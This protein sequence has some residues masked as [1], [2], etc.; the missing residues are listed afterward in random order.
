MKSFKRNVSIIMSLILFA[1]SGNPSVYAQ[2]PM[3]QDIGQETAAACNV[4]TDAGE[5]GTI[6]P[7]FQMESG[8]SAVIKVT[9]D[10]GYVVSEFTVN[11]EKKELKGLEYTINDASGNYWISV[12]FRKKT[13]NITVSAETGGSIT[14]NRTVAYGESTTFKFTPDAGYQIDKVYLDNEPVVLNSDNTY[15]LNNVKKTHSLQAVF[16]EVE[17]SIN[18]K[19][20]ENG[21][22]IVRYEGSPIESGTVLKY[23]SIIEM[24]NIPQEHYN[25]IRYEINGEPYMGSDYRVN[26]PVD[27]TAVFSEKIYKINTRQQGS[28]TL[29][30][31]DK[32]QVEAGEKVLISAVPDTGYKVSSLIV[33][34]V[35]VT[36]LLNENFEY[37]TGDTWSGLS[38]NVIFEKLK[39]N[40][41]TECG[42]NGTITSSRTVEYG[43]DAIIS[44]IPDDAYE[45]DKVYVDGELVEVEGTDYI[46]ENV[47]SDHEVYVE[48]S[49]KYCEVEVEV[50]ENGTASPS[51]MVP[52]NDEY[53]VEI[54]PDEGYQIDVILLNGTPV[55]ASHGE[56]VIKN[57]IDDCVLQIIFEPNEIDI[58]VIT[59]VSSKGVHE[60][61]V[62]WNDVEN[63]EGYEI[64]RMSEYDYDYKLIADVPAAYFGQ[65]YLDTKRICGVEY[66][67]MVRAYKIRYNEKLYGEISEEV[68][69]MTKPGK[70]TGTSLET[71]GVK[72][73]N[74][75]WKRITSAS[76][77]EIY[78]S[79]ERDGEYTLK[80]DIKGNKTSSKIITGLSKGVRYYV[81]VRAYRIYEDEKIY[82]SF[83]SVRNAATAYLNDVTGVKAKMKG[84]E[85]SLI[86]WKKVSGAEGYD[87]FWC[88]TKNGKYEKI[89]SVKAGKSLEYKDKFYL[90]GRN[91]YKVRAYKKI[92]GKKVYG[93]LSK[94][95][96]VNAVIKQK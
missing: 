64:Y 43:K 31:D 71:T 30:T 21:T 87:I 12:K 76:G 92:N 52:Y 9:P 85:Y 13:F 41:T 38:I 22:F 42:E 15:T 33:N 44:F 84:F 45:V 5:G 39:Y 69:G 82:G 90:T 23:G 40:I 19:L 61:M 16:K 34:D 57:I 49:D 7:S 78:I 56:Y 73:L 37:E 59:K 81:K 25:F 53:V 75:K 51:T 60:L 27:I 11:D 8:G 3:N 55:F 66:Y 83:S 10:E 67:Y 28:G 4:A 70:V 54:E 29:L 77:Y 68:S 18:I 79:R 48:F 62:E 89:A 95:S 86:T 65:S 58:P 88:L 17:C 20:P 26:G 72:E 32:I 1:M 93:C 96:S 2:E 36:N 80:A 91:Y 46:F 94:P 6:T 47:S 74:V 24:Y 35:D 14:G 63:A 50:G